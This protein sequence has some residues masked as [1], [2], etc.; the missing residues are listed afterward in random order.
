M[1]PSPAFGRNQSSKKTRI[2]RMTRI[3]RPEYFSVPSVSL[4]V[5][6][7]CGDLTMK[8]QRHRGLRDNAQPGTLPEPNPFRVLRRFRGSPLCIRNESNHERNER[9]E[10]FIHRFRRFPQITSISGSIQ[11]IQSVKICEIC[12]STPSSTN[13]MCSRSYAS[14]PTEFFARRANSNRLYYGTNTDFKDTHEN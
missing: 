11:S 1:K 8:P 13:V 7:S 4:W 2:S 3:R 5:N 10:N 12:G 9:H 14:A 6:S